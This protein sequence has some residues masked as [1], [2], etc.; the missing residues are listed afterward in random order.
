MTTQM[1]II[2][3]LR[4]VMPPTSDTMIEILLLDSKSETP[5][6]IV[7][8]IV[9]T[10]VVTCTVVVGVVAIS[11][12]GEHSDKLVGRVPGTEQLNLPVMKRTGTHIIIILCISITLINLTFLDVSRS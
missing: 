4:I 7:G 12:I 2:L 9:V 5:K 1:I 10:R 8:S 3:M 11:I 6:F